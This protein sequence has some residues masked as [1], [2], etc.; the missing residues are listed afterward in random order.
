MIVERDEKVD[1]IKISLPDAQKSFMKVLVSDKEG[2]SDYVM[3][4][5]EIE[6]D[7]YTP[8]HDH[9]WPHINYIT[10]GSGSLFLDGEEIPLEEGSF[11][12]IPSGK[13]HQFKNSGN[14]IFKF[15]CIVPKEGHIL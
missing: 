10:E 4:L 13:V 5:L 11:A 2:W 7:G 15:L 1:R 8:K 14:R 6:E 3:R 9:P 12:Y